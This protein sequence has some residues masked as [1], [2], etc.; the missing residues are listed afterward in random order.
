MKGL[1]TFLCFVLSLVSVSAQRKSIDSLENLLSRSSGT[2]HVDQLNAYA[3]S[4]LSY[5]YSKAEYKI[6]ESLKLSRELK[7]KKG[8]V[9]ALLYYGIIESNSG[10]DSLALALY[11][12]ARSLSTK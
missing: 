4:V 6:N 1:L 2:A 11:K 9:E 10:N 12:E 8:E 3:Y 7:Y 5:D